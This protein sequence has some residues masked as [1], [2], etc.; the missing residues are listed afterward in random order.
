VDEEGV[1]PTPLA[2]AWEGQLGDGEG[3]RKAF[4]R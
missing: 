4:V 3:R 1:E 2:K